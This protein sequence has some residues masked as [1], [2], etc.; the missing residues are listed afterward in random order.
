M[1][2]SKLSATFCTATVSPSVWGP[3]VPAGTQAIHNDLVLSKKYIYNNERVELC[4][5]HTWCWADWLEAL[6][7]MDNNTGILKSESRSAK[8]RP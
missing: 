6:K 8:N 1:W 5:Y 2:L 4:K 3:A 7:K